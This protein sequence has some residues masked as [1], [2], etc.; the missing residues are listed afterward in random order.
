MEK[1]HEIDPD[2]YGRK[3]SDLRKL[4]ENKIFPGIESVDRLISAGNHP[5]TVER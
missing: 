1:C 3:N 4:P 5:G 2:Q